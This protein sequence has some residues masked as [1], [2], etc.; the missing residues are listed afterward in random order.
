M[1]SVNGYQSVVT[2]AVLHRFTELKRFAK[3]ILHVRQPDN[4]PYLNGKGREGKRRDDNILCKFQILPISQRRFRIAINLRNTRVLMEDVKK[5]TGN[6][7][8]TI[9]S[10][11]AN[12]LITLNENQ[13]IVRRYF[14]SVDMPKQRGSQSFFFFLQNLGH[15]Y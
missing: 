2:L 8:C 9:R 14:V 3:A 1:N 11:R 6:L 4:L 15:G 10:F 13:L 12:R 5:I 7:T